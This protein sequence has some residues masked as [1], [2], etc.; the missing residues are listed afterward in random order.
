MTTEEFVKK[1]P[2]EDG[3]EV[4]YH[5]SK[6]EFIK[7]NT[8]VRDNVIFV[9]DPKLGIIQ[10]PVDLEPRLVYHLWEEP[11]IVTTKPRGKDAVGNVITTKN[12]GYYYFDYASEKVEWEK[13][14]SSYSIIGE[15]DP[16]FKYE[17]DALAYAETKCNWFLEPLPEVFKFYIYESVRETEIVLVYDCEMIYIEEGKWSKSTFV[18]GVYSQFKPKLNR[19]LFDDIKTG[20]WIAHGYAFDDNFTIG[21]VCD[22]KILWMM[23]NGCFT[24]Q[25]REEFVSYDRDP[26]FKITKAN[27]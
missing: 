27:D 14:S 9:A 17:K 5:A 18:D 8:T 13:F 3:E 23:D 21:L 1:Y 2:F 19:L 11:Q 7:L 15:G 4:W 25:L 6:V 26:L 22:T 10:I 24:E 12:E 20:D 16:C